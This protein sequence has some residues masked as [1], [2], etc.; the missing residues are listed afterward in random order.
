MTASVLVLGGS[1]A[2][3]GAVVRRFASDGQDVHFT[4]VKSERA[5]EA[6]LADCEDLPGR[7]TADRVNVREEDDIAKA[8]AACGD[9]LRTVVFSAVSGV[10]KPLDE[11]RRKHWDW[12]FE[13]NARAFG[14]LA[15]DVLRQLAPTGGSLMALTALGARR[16]MP[17]YALVGAAK[18]AVE[19]TVRYAAAEGGPNGIRVN[20]VC[21]GV[22]H[23]K[24]LDAFPADARRIVEDAE[25]RTP[26]GRLVTTEEVADLVA[27]LAGDAG[28]MITGQVVV[29]DG[30]WELVVPWGSGQ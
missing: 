11:A 9:E 18:A 26:M 2:I 17:D 14:L 7:V 12:T 10:L 13:I 23:T 27:F 4:Y 20:A 30:G 15:R 5:A 8:L 28:R 16:V 19:S 29:I 3:G 1:G 22:I 24:A 25:A 6:V 21:P